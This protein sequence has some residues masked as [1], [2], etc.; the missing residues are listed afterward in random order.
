MSFWTGLHEEAVQ[1][2]SLCRLHKECGHFY[3]Y[4]LCVTG[5]WW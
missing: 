2:H 3:L 1:C 5:I 4:T